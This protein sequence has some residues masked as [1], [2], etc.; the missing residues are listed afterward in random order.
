IQKARVLGGVNVPVRD[1]GIRKKAGPGVD[2]ANCPGRGVQRHEDRLC[3]RGDIEHTVRESGAAQG[4]D[5]VTSTELP[6]ERKL[7]DIRLVKLV[8]VRI[9]HAVAGVEAILW[10]PGSRLRGI[11]AALVLANRQRY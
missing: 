4:V 5:G 1:R 2:P 8:L 3:Q 7:S 11:V 6:L 10:P 9:E